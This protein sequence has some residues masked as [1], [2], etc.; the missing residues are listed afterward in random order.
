ME[1]VQKCPFLQKF[2]LSKCPH[3]KNC[4]KLDEIKTKKC[5]YLHSN[6]NGENGSTESK[7]PFF[8]KN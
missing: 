6:G 3:F 7:C 8:T 5:P 2:D 4:P 1:S